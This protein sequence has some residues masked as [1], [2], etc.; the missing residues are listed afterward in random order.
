MVGSGDKK[1]HGIKSPH[2]GGDQWRP[3]GPFARSRRNVPIGVGG[4]AFRSRAAGKLVISKVNAFQH[5]EKCKLPVSLCQRAK[6]WFV[7]ESERDGPKPKP[8]VG[9]KAEWL[10]Q[11]NKL[12]L[13]ECRAG[14]V[15]LKR[16]QAAAPV[17]AGA[18]KD[19]L[20]AA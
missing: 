1:Q 14:H 4:V 10:Q 7:V 6:V 5:R 9:W 19:G 8:C 12:W 16:V 20:K 2:D 3:P 11:I 15:M 13:P 17:H 18:C